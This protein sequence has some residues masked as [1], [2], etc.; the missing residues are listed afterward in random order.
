MHILGQHMDAVIT[1]Q[2]HRK[3]SHFGGKKVKGFTEIQP[4]NH[5]RTVT[6]T[7]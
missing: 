4:T 6:I 5:L 3:A 7:H 2:E 1:Q